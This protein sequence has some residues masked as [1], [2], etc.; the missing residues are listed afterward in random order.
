MRSRDPIQHTAAVSDECGQATLPRADVFTRRAA[1][2][3]LLFAG[4]EI[5]GRASPPSPTKKLETMSDPRVKT[6]GIYLSAWSA[7]PEDERA[8]RLGES[9]SKDIVFTNPMQTR[10]GLAEVAVH[11]QGF[12]QR[13]P[14][15]SFRMNE[16]LG[17]EKH[18]I[19]TWQFVDPQGQPGFWGYDV[20]AYDGQGLIESILLFSHVDKQMLK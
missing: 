20:L 14:G 4:W 11:L 17:W 8:R 18:G 2:A 15:G 19:A 6:Y 9:L 3:A 7:I 12:Q 10:R 13:S 5:S 1:V 16:M